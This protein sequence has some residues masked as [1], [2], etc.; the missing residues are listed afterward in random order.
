MLDGIGL[1]ES[2]Q[3]THVSHIPQWLSYRRFTSMIHRFV[4]KHILHLPWVI[5]WGVDADAKEAAFCRALSQ[6]PW[7]YHFTARRF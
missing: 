5:V 6:V 2:F 7:G 1:A 4:L 3:T